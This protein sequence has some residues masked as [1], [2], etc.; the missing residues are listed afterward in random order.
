[1]SDKP[2]Q[3]DPAQSQRFVEAA[4]QIEADETGK[5]F[6]RAI[7]KIVPAKRRTTTPKR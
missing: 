5:V 7:K 1:M 4:K 6:A 3:D 2:K